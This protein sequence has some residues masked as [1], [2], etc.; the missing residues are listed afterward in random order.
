M[1][2]HDAPNATTE[3]LREIGLFGG[4]LDDTLAQLSASLRA[5]SVP[6][7]QTVFREG[8]AG[9]EMYVV[10]DGELEVQK[11]SRGG[12]D[13]RVALLGIHD[14]FGEMSLLDIQPRSASVRTVSP[15]HLIVVG[16]ADLDAL[17]RRDLKAYSLLVLN[18]AREMSRR[19]R[20]ADGILADVIAQLTDS[21]LRRR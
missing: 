15:C 19:L 16:S 4:L 1:E 8:D 7:G 9:R 11:R 21:Y 12:H 20:V 5:I 18:I 2:A 3:Q 13:A 10:L 17:Y 6:A 14:W